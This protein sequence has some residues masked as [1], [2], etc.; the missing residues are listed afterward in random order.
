MFDALQYL[1]DQ[2]SLCY[3]PRRTLAFFLSFNDFL[4]MIC[5]SAL[6]RHHIDNYICHASGMAFQDS[7]L[8][9]IFTGA[10]AVTQS[11]EI[12]LTHRGKYA[13]MGFDAPCE[14]V[15]YPMFHCHELER[16]T[17]CSWAQD[18]RSLQTRMRTQRY[19]Q[20]CLKPFNVLGR[21]Q[22]ALLPSLIVLP[23]PI[24]HLHHNRMPHFDQTF[25]N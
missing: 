15:L 5:L 8:P 13:A 1:N 9:F 2:T 25:S 14:A 6:V 18:E 19:M 4:S 17:D 10:V 22:H 24:R 11:S 12:Q 3:I 16:R 21:P 23:L 7:D 20:L